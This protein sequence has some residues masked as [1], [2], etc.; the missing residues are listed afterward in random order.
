[1][2]FGK[3]FNKTSLISL[4]FAG[5]LGTP[6]AAET[7]NCTFKVPDRYEAW[8]PTTVQI[9][10]DREKARVTVTTGLFENVGKRA[11]DGELTINNARRVT[12]QFSVDNTDIPI[13][14]HVNRRRVGLT[15][16][17]VSIQKA[18]HSATLRAN[19]VSATDLGKSFHGKG[20]CIVK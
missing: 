18:D 7:L 6:V 10:N 16:Y 15:I 4:V 14:R 3:T 11:F 1:M 13:E 9:T 12:F 8:V 19:P 17:S 2:M 5:L 20:S